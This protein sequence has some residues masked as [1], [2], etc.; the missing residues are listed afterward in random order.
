MKTVAIALFF[1]FISSSLMAQDYNAVYPMSENPSIHL[2]T[3]MYNSETIL[4]EAHPTVRFS[5]YNNIQKALLNNKHFAESLYLSAQPQLRMYTD[6]SLPVKTPTY[7][8]LLGTQ[9]LYR[10]PMDDSKELNAHFLGLKLESGHYSN[11]QSGCAFS[12]ELADGNPLCEGVYDNFTSESKLAD[13]LNRIDGNFSTNLSEIMIQYR[14]YDLDE[15]FFPEQMHAISLGYTLFHDKM[16]GFIDIGG[17]SD[18]DIDIYGHHRLNFQYEFMHK[19]N[20]DWGSRIAFQQKIELII[21]AHASVHPLRSETKVMYYPFI[22]SKVFGFHASFIYGHD[23]YNYRFLDSGS[24][25]AGGIII[26]LFPPFA[27]KNFDS[28]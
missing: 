21:G 20:E 16:F 7:R 25:V 26:D 14:F 10:L 4:F 8:I 11:G 28:F 5:F 3:R 23:N 24:Q 13:S 6:K 22:N 12:S 18:N 2:M 15:D 27:M 17:Y 1:L 19:L 9:N